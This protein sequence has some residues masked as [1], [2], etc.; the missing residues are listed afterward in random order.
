LCAKGLDDDFDKD[1]KWMN[2]FCLEARSSKQ[3]PVL[4]IRRIH[5]QR[6]SGVL[7]L[8]ARQ[9]EPARAGVAPNMVRAGQAGTCFCLRLALLFGDSGLST[10]RD[11]CN[12]HADNIRRRILDF[13]R[14]GFYR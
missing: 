11:G 7:F 8:L 13:D 9:P 5:H 4:G 14:S 12:Q 1:A 3:E 6:A 2:R 10:T